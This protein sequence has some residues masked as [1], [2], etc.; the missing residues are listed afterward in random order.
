MNDEP[1]L[2]AQALA[3]PFGP[4]AL[5]LWVELASMGNPDAPDELRRY[6]RGEDAALR[7]P[8]RQ[9]LDDLELSH[10]DPMP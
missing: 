8:A 10:D 2:H 5:A 6:A 7:D 3:L 1:G 9:A 4:E